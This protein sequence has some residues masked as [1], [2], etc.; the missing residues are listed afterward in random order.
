VLTIEG[1]QLSVG[2]EEADAVAQL[3]ACC[4]ASPSYVV[5][6]FVREGVEQHGR[7]GGNIAVYGVSG[8]L[9]I[10]GREYSR[11]PK[12]SKKA[13]QTGGRRAAIWLF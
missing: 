7:P 6:L 4:G 11:G 3:K 8:S 2:M 12:W 10:P 1:V 9:G 5:R 13:P